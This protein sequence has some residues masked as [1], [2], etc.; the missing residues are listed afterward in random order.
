MR[1]PSLAIMDVILEE[2]GEWE[3]VDSLRHIE[4]WRRM[5]RGILTLRLLRGFW[6]HLGQYLQ[7]VKKRGLGN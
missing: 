1:A 3:V 7:D 5:V 4:V 6:G 2:E